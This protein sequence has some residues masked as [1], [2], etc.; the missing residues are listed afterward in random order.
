[1]YLRE[2]LSQKVSNVGGVFESRRHYA[3]RAFVHVGI[4]RQ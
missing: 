2:F 1:M 3:M 4:L